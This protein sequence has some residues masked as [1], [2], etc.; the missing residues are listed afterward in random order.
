METNVTF[1]EK[2]NR[3][4]QNHDISFEE[5]M[6]LVGQTFTQ[7]IERLTQDFQKHLH[8]GLRGLRRELRF[9]A[10]TAKIWEYC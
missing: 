4:T 7:Q 6:S 5:K 9:F 3:I 2:M 1:Q 10:K 8:Q